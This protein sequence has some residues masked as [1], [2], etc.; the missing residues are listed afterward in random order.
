MYKIG[1]QTNLSVAKDRSLGSVLALI[2]VLGVTLLAPSTTRAEELRLGIFQDH[3]AEVRTYFDTHGCKPLGPEDNQT[4]QILTE[5]LLLCKALSDA[6]SPY[7]ITL[8]P[9][10]INARLLKDIS[11]GTL[12]ASAYAIWSKEP[13]LYPNTAL[14]PALLEKGEFSK[15]LYTRPALASKFEYQSKASFRGLTGVANQ[16]WHYDW[17]H[18]HCAG[19]YTTHINQYQQM[20]ALIE[21][22]KVDLV[23][24]TFGQETDLQRRVFGISLY[25]LPGIKLAFDDSLHF[26]F[27][28]QTIS[29]KAAHR[30]V[31]NELV[32]MKRNGEIDAAYTQLG[33]LNPSTTHWQDVGCQ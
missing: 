32:R 18:M 6:D 28:S 2:L 5:F 27:S 7:Q 3:Y 29:G 12:D 14:S 26:V 22:G 24:L 23:P 30:L 17:R 4:N 16:N 8:V 11:L 21:Q 13:A 31:E 1:L 25:P 15:G 33:I 9:Y 19:I 20:F 10:P